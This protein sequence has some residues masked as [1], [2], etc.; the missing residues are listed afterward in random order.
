MEAKRPAY[1]LLSEG[2]EL[3]WRVKRARELLR[4]CRVCPRSCGINR[5]EGEVGVCKAPRQAMASSSGP[6]F[7]EEPP[8]VGRFGSGTIFFAHCNLKCVFCQNYDISQL[9]HGEQVSSE[10]LARHML[11]LQRL[12]CHNINL[13]TPTPYVPQ[14]LEALLIAAQSGL[15]IPLVYNCGGY[16]SVETLKILDGVVDIYMP[17]MKYSDNQVAQ[18]YS[19]VDDYFDHCRAALKEMHRQVGDLQI[20]GYGIA[21]RGLL[22][23]HLVLPHGLAGSRGVLEFI[24]MEL[25]RG[26][27]VNIMDQY[28][29]TYRAHEYVGVN[30]RITITEYLEVVEMARKLGLH[31]GF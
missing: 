4:S 25:S 7:G 10:E 14:I 28:R 9:G 31:R 30:R 8:L 29:P 22:I 15:E 17:D 12:G 20:D 27:Y 21:Q 23:R 16:E 18:R 11:V 2:G 3:A 13:V 19:K 24:A 1:L 6:H 26:S 5:L